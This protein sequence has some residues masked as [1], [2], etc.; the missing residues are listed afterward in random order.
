MKKSYK[1]IASILVFAA[2]II[3]F[4]IYNNAKKEAAEN[5]RK[6][7]SMNSFEN[8][9]KTLEIREN[10][11]NFLLFQ[12]KLKIFREKERAIDEFIKKNTRYVKRSN[13]KILNDDFNEINYYL[14]KGESVL[15]ISTKEADDIQYD[16]IKIGYD[17]E[18]IGWVKAE[19]LTNSRTFFIDRVYDNVDYGVFE[20]TDGYKNNPMVK[21]RGVYVTGHKAAGSIDSLIE[22]AK[23]TDINTFVIDFKDD[24]ENMLFFSE[25]AEKN[26]PKAN[27]TVYIKDPESFMKKLKD[28]NIYLIARVVTFKSPRYALAH[29]EKSIIYKGSGAIFKTGDGISMVFTL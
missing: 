3:S 23:K 24:K 5:D 25:A 17:D 9:K 12:E 26:S 13:P 21:V 16:L 6:M 4:T 22:L 14:K 28:N 29:P 18:P 7:R 20:K 27:N 19:D 1:I 10:Y 11:L 8:Y 2:L 15:S